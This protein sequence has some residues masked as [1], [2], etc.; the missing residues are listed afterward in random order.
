MPERI[1]EISRAALDKWNNLEKKQKFWIFA[2]IGIL[3]LAI[4]IAIFLATRITY[5]I[6][7][8]ELG[9]A[10]SARIST[11]LAAE[12]I[13]H[14]TQDG[15]SVIEVESSR[16][17]EA[18]LLINTLLTEPLR[19]F[20][21]QDALEASGIGATESIT[22]ESLLRARVNDFERAIS[23]MNGVIS[24]TVE[25]SPV[26]TNRFFIQQTEQPSAVAI[27][28]TARPLTRDEGRAVAIFLQRSIIGLELERI[29]VID[30]D[31]NVIFSGLEEGSSDIAQEIQELNARERMLIIAQVSQMFNPHFDRVSVIPSLYYSSEI[32]E[33]EEIVYTPS[34]EE[35][36]TGLVQFISER[37]QR[38]SGGD[39]AAEPGLGSNNATF[40]SYPWATPSNIDA[41]LRE[42]ERS[43]LVNQMITR[44]QN[45]INSYLRENSSI[46]ATFSRVVTH[47]EELFRADNPEATDLD[48]ERYKRENAHSVPIDDPEAIAVFAS[49]IRSATGIPEVTVTLMALPQFVDL[50]PSSTPW[51][52]IVMFG[53]LALIIGIIAI[54]LIRKN[55]VEEII[56]EEGEESEI[57]PEISIED[58]LSDTQMEE[59]LEELDETEEEPSMPTIEQ[60]E[61]EVKVKL[62]I[63]I[64]DKPESAANLL[65][66]WLNEAEV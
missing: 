36:M 61:S 34:D 54:A 52:Q 59:K 47:Y 50:P 24:A 15:G 21:Y 43:Y 1:I 55:I 10:E 49:A 29:D 33:W 42:S 46:A 32:T 25:L 9:L 14:R 18:R 5:E 8:S 41:R 40:P 23:S 16:V 58:I 28:T 57:L 38:A 22:Q 64:D 65:R 19:N 39:P 12:G 2:A 3:V 53:L 56:Q 4:I 45:F 13:R 30:S 44:G 37:D 48:W 60:Q 62:G 35:N 7:D 63:F 51:N 20:S 26:D 17:D 27:L 31:F 66:H 6:A 11:A